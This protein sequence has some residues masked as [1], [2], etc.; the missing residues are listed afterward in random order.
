MEARRFKASGGDVLSDMLE[1]L[2]D[3]VR[4]TYS[5]MHPDY[6]HCYSYY[7]FYYYYFH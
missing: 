6:C 3:S 2:G 7:H 5:I 1:L 4:D